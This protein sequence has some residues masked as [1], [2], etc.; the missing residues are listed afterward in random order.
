MSTGGN[1]GNKDR[2]SSTLCLHGSLLNKLIKVNSLFS[3]CS[4]LKEMMLGQQCSLRLFLSNGNSLGCPDCVRDLL[5]KCPQ[6]LPPEK[7]IT[8]ATVINESYSL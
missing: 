5:K 4:R 3:C 6:P 7:S 8:E 1:S 2:L